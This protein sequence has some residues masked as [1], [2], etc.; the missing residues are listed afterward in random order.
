MSDKFDIRVRRKQFTEG[1]MERYKNY[2]SLMKRHK[3]SGRKKA[4]GIAII[5]F[6]VILGLALA[7][8][9]SAVTTPKDNNNSKHLPKKEI[10]S[11]RP[12]SLN[13]K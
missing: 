3:R 5:V 2:E 6:V 11:T 10:Q 7:L 9:V 13:I 8:I 4:R 1:R 12:Q